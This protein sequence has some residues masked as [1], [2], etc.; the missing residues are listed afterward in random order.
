MVHGTLLATGRTL[1]L[2]RLLQSTFRVVAVDRRGTGASQMSKPGSV[3]IG[4]HLADLIAVLDDAGVERAAVLGHSFGANL[5]LELAARHPDR[6]A[7]VVAYEPP[8]LALAGPELAARMA[9]LPAAVAAAFSA[10]GSPAAA[11]TFLRAVIG[12]DAWESFTPPQR[13]LSQAEG[14]GALADSD[15]SGLDPD[16]LA[17]IQCPVS[18]ATGAATDPFYLPLADALAARIPTARRVT[19]PGL[20][21]AAPMSNPEAVA[22]L[23][24]HALP[25]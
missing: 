22:A 8:Y 14:A 21:H 13:A 9:P 23:V 10:G 5:S 4:R 7:S 18:I 19:L 2:A 25:V 24:V 12:D 17:R 20:A 16:G 15:M 3:S 1:P 11:E 6:V